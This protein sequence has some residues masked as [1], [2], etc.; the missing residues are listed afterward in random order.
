MWL[1]NWRA[2]LLHPFQ[3]KTNFLLKCGIFTI[4]LFCLGLYSAMLAP[5]DYL[6]GIYYKIMYVHV[7]SAWISMG[8]YVFMASISFIFIVYKIPS[9]ALIAESSSIV[10]AV[11][12]FI[13]LVTGSIWGM[14]TWGTWWI[15]DARL[16]SMLVLLF[17]YISCIALRASFTTD[18]G[19][20]ITA[21]FSVFGLINIPIIKFSVDVWNTLHQPSSFIKLS[22]PTVHSS[23]IPPLLIMLVSMLSMAW[24]CIVLLVKS[25]QLE[26]KYNRWSARL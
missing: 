25:K 24:M 18:F 8:L 26:S 14:P 22:A 23:M 2:I 15:W 5:N 3:V 6:Q 16:T 21:Y 20:V 13:T 10:G 12:T 9:L 1:N 19:S 17:I 4:F 7:P 11:F